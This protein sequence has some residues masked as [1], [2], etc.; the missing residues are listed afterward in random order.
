MTHQC[1]TA[2][3]RTVAV[4]Y[5]DAGGQPG[6]REMEVAQYHKCLEV[7]LHPVAA[8]ADVGDDL[9]LHCRSDLCVW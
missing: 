7:G 1:D 4:L 8:A 5:H 6:R 9:G 3:V 2:H